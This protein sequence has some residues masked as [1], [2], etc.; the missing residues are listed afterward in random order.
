[1]N[2]F[3]HSLQTA[4][5]VR[6]EL[7]QQ[8][9]AISAAPLVEAACAHWKLVV[10]RIPAGH[11]L[12][13]GSDANIDTKQGWIYVTH[14]LDPALEA[15]LLAHE[16]GHNFLHQTVSDQFGV[17]RNTLDP[18]LDGTPAS[19]TVEAYGPRERQ[20]LQAN[21]FAR[22]FLLPRVLARKLFLEDA[23]SASEIA[24]DLIIP[25]EVVRLQLVDALLLPEVP[26]AFDVSTPKAATEVQKLAVESPH[27]HTLVTA[28]PG[29]GKTTTLMLRL[30]KILKAGADPTSIVVLTF[31]NKAAREIVERL[32]VAGIAGA[33]R[34]WVGTFHS[35]GLEFLRKFGTL[36]GLTEQVSVLDNLGALAMLE[37]VLPT[38]PLTQFDPLA[39]PVDWL[40][41]VLRA[42]ARCKD[43]LIDAAGYLKEIETYP[44]T[45][46]EKQG[47]RA[48]A[49]RI[50]AAYEQALEKRRLVDFND[51]LGK[52]VKL[53]G[54]GD[55][56]I[57]AYL[58]GIQHVVVDEYQDVN[59]ASAQL[60]KLLN[61]HARTAWAVGDP[62]QA[63]YNFMGASSAN[64]SRFPKDFPG[65][66]TIPLGDNHRSS[67]EI[68]DAYHQVSR[69]TP[70]GNPALLLNAAKGRSGLLPS[71]IACDDD[72]DEIGAIA[73]Q[74]QALQGAVPLS[75]QAVI[76]YHNARATE[77][78]QGLERRGIA[79]LYLGSVYERAEIKELLCILHLSIDQAGVALGADW[80]S[81]LLRVPIE[82]VAKILASPPEG[83]E[84]KP[85]WERDRSVLSA[86]GQNAVGLFAALVAPLRKLVSPWEALCSILLEDGRILRQQLK[87]ESQSGINERLAIWQFLHACRAPDGLSSYPTIRNLFDR[88]RRR[89]R[90]GQDKA[91]RH[92][93]PE[94]EG[95][96]AVRILTAHQSKG[97]EFEVVHFAEMAAKVY[98]PGN[99]RQW[100]LLPDELLV[101]LTGMDQNL[102]RRLERHN[103]LYV[104]CSRAKGQLFIYARRDEPLPAALAAAL[105]LP[106]QAGTRVSAGPTPTLPANPLGA[107]TIS[108][109]DLIQFRDYCPRRVEYSQRFGH[110]PPTTLPIYRLMSIALS[111]A[112]KQVA[113]KAELRT[114]N[115]IA[116]VVG[117]ELKRLELSDLPQS[118]EMHSRLTSLVAE[119]A[120][121]YAEGGK[122]HH[123]LTLQIEGL[124]VT[125]DAHQ[126]LNAGGRDVSRL[127]KAAPRQFKRHAQALGVLVKTH[128]EATGKR[129]EIEGAILKDG[130]R[131]KPTNVRAPTIEAYKATAVEIA[132][133]EFPAR[134]SSENCPKCAY[135]ILCNSRRT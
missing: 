10:K 119:G 12:L 85:W 95:L 41:D 99:K 101:R 93:P 110:L 79:V 111:R 66:E 60:V 58:Q 16:L 46:P 87:D 92:V 57:N 114:K 106:A 44:E 126:Q 13:R 18:E 37:E 45:E 91:M 120:R 118:T 97:L 9:K 11:P 109:E 78:A 82:D 75:K 88:I 20:E 127:F 77:I 26:N 40:P 17:S 48:D 23:K 108:L 56:A 100:P 112:I 70:H 3:A 22:E 123:I 128:E 83:V 102:G 69:G 115:G 31:S 103:L 89:I 7:G 134:V 39:D 1:M 133:G 54:L 84:Q 68:A 29:T 47:R 34:V 71:T 15:F 104:G 61:T 55:P 42:I 59:R 98:E 32:R 49:A 19:R 25:L 64:I 51:L 63:I 130:T 135:F 125:V 8:G 131:P 30:A 5:S 96:N 121:L 50:F 124:S 74:V 21:V 27:R 129:V 117:A 80:T 105:K 107:K 116:T 33:E 72:T 6:Q 24:E 132:R 62:H 76:V 73:G 52:T 2:P 122:A 81:P 94:A 14:G 67:Q 53:M 35:F 38:L 43:D 113:T 65:A 90:L 4:R 36:C 28:G 86:A